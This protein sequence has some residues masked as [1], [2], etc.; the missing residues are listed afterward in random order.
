MR[1]GVERAW[2]F[3]VLERFGKDLFSLLSKFP[4]QIKMGKSTILNIGI[5]LIDIIQ[6]VHE[7]GYV[8]GDLKNDNLV[9]GYSGGDR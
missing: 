3:L 2:H 5:Q 6:T 4:S 8:H 7:A 9:I 1:D